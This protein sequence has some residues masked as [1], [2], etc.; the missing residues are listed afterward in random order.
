MSLMRYMGLTKLSTAELAET[1]TNDNSK[2]FHYRGDN[3]HYRVEGNSDEGAPVLIMLHGIMAS[4]QTW[5]GWVEHLK[6][7]YRIVRL[8]V[9][10]FGL[11]GAISDGDTSIEGIVDR[12]NA[13]MNHLELDK[14]V[15]IGNSLGGYISWSFAAEHPE[16]VQALVL[17][18][19]AGYPMQLPLIMKLFTTPYLRHLVRVATPQF[20]VRYIL[21]EVYGDKRRIAEEKIPCYQ[22]MMLHKGNPLSLLKIF[23]E[24]DN[25]TPERV[26]EVTAP[27][28]IQWGEK[29]IW[30]TPK[31]APLFHR[32]IKGSE[33]IMYPGVGHVPME[34]IPEQSVKDAEAFLSRVL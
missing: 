4:L 13:L 3:I 30:I 20:I 16:R 17:L 15:L 9:P 29:D 12:I 21:G 22:D 11:S 1:Y 26:A 32:D 28:L 24:L 10:G 6:E 25:M 2:F 34:E 14:A 18:D 7:K 19:A 27:T 31:N 23:E 33:L 8:D 5:D